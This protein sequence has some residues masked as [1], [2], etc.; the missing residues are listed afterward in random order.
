MPLPPRS[1]T[2]LVLRPPPLAGLQNGTTTPCSQALTCTSSSASAQ[3]SCASSACSS[4]VAAAHAPNGTQQQRSSSSAR[5]QPQQDPLQ[6]ASRRRPPAATPS[7]RHW[8]VFTGYEEPDHE[9]LLRSPHAPRTP[10]S[11]LSSSQPLKSLGAAISPATSAALQA[12]HQHA[13]GSA[14]RAPGSSSSSVLLPSAGR[15]RHGVTPPLFGGLGLGG[16]MPEPHQEV[17]GGAEATAAAGTPLRSP[18]LGLAAA[19]EAAASK[20]AAAAT[21]A[22]A[23]AGSEEEAQPGG[24]Q[25]AWP[26]AGGAGRAE[27]PD[28]GAAVQQRLQQFGQ[29]LEQVEQDAATWTTLLATAWAAAPPG[30]RAPQ[31]EREGGAVGGM[32]SIG[33]V[34][35]ERQHA[36]LLACALLERLERARRRTAGAL[37]FSVEEEGEDEEEDEGMRGSISVGTLSPSEE[38]P[39]QEEEAAQEVSSNGGAALGKRLAH[40]AALAPLATSA[41]LTPRLGGAVAV[42]HVVS[43]GARCRDRPAKLVL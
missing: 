1:L 18:M 2:P 3:S 35:G 32:G 19:L 7:P 33:G 21:A 29:L 38:Q 27:Q 8:T 5:T 17:D 40:P 9:A 42:V 16:A 36:A 31:E 22:A 23:A 14:A 12:A 20:A 28:D 34:P 26:A 30:A 37:S 39:E 6:P 24:T 4:P 25:Q 41:A 10:A 11:P 13:T 43:N 15:L